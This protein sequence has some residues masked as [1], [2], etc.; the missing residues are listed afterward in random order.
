M[1]ENV[2]LTK[3]PTPANTPYS[4]IEPFIAVVCLQTNLDCRNLMDFQIAKDYL[5]DL[6]LLN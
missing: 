4:F 5:E 6:K 3:L 1:I 2:L